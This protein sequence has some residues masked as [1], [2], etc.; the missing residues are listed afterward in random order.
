[1]FAAQ[2]LGTVF[3]FLVA[4]LTLW[5]LRV[6]QGDRR[7]AA[8]RLALADEILNVADESLADDRDTDP[9]PPPSGMRSLTLVSGR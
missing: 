9:G 8:R 3:T 2:I 6:A 7:E 5:T 1:M 4:G